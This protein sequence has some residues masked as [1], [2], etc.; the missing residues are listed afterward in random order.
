M[1]HDTQNLTLGTQ[2]FI[3]D[4]QLKDSIDDNEED[5]KVNEIADC[6]DDLEPTKFGFR[7][8][9]TLMDEEPCDIGISCFNIDAEV[10]SMTGNSI[11]SAS[12]YSHFKRSDTA[13]NRQ[14]N[15]NFVSVSPPDCR[16]RNTCGR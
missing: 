3:I 10:G 11:Q 15:E 2:N 4:E 12:R 1:T 14:T 7:V 16:L 9:V 8:K 5:F 13:E 6:F